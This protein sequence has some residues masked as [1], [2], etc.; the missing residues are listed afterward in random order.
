MV[1][2]ST[3]NYSKLVYQQPQNLRQGN[4]TVGEYTTEFY[5]LV[6]RSDLVETDEQI[7]S[8]Y[9]GGM[10]VQ[11]QDTLNLFDPFSVAKA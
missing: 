6:A 10:R 11:F 8:R 9:I 2:L 3:T 7:E 5:E 4:R 1:N